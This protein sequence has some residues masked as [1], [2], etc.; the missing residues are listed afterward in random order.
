MDGK[1]WGRRLVLGA[2]AGL[3][4]GG[5]A[6]QADEAAPWFDGPRPRPVAYEA[7]ALLAEAPTHGLDAGD[8]GVA[9]LQAAL[10]APVTEPARAAVVGGAMSTAL[11][12]YLAD[13]RDGRIDPRRIHH[14]FAVPRGQGEDAAARL[15]AAL[16]SG[17][18]AEAVQAAAP[19][20]PLYGRLREALAQYR[21]LV[22]HAGWAAA[23]PRPAGGRLDPGQPYADLARLAQ[24]LAAL[25]DLPQA[26]PLPPR[27]EG[28]LVEA[29]RAFQR[30]HGLADDG[31]LGRATLAQLEVTPA[32]RVRQ[33]ELTMERLRWTPL[34]QAPRMIVVNI[35]EFVLRAY[36]VR[37]GRI[38][39]QQEMRVIVGKALDTRTP[40]FDE[41]M[42]AIEFSPYWNV[43][44]SIAR[45]E[46]LPRLRR[47][48]GYF[49]RQ[50]FEFVGAD[51]TV[52]TVLTPA[53]LDALRDGRLR[54]RQRPG[55]DNALGDI[56]FVFPNRDAIY[57][58]HT[59]ST[60]LFAR[61]RRDFSH[62]CVRVER[63]VD[64]ARFVLAGQ[65]E[66]TEERIR[67]TMAAGESFTLRLAEP[68][69][70][71]IAYGTTLVRDG[72]I[73]FF[74]DLYGHDRA[75]DAALRQRPP[76][77]PLLPTP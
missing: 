46:L 25:G 68:L 61:D 77:P 24:R 45:K 15:R 43:P 62:G 19:A 32:R 31:V 48:P 49:E 4:A 76:A 26:T 22:G 65:P 29:L 41:L 20:L 36:E 7:L 17:R 42:R 3:L 50:G 67:A 37:E 34:T 8:Y 70:V 38:A 35:P 55:P 18:L 56:K 47:D 60:G 23:L 64:L 53:H 33:I 57:L 59:P 11:R 72:R 58:H 6:A 2:L 30:R 51:G 10:A 74:D 54:L 66:W 21:G 69:P 14:D 12:R 9:A 16:Q 71:L 1:R 28:A 13:L 75:L 73:H 44:A 5:V 27:F 52:E 40:L 63:P 39:V